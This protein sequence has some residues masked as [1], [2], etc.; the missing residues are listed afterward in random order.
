MTNPAK[1][2]Q[3]IKSQITRFSGKVSQE[4]DKPKR[5]FINEMIYGIQASKD[6][7]L[8]NIARAL[9]EDIS[10]VKTV[11]RLSRQIG[12]KDLT[13]RIGNRLIEEGKPFIGKDTVL[14]LDLSDISKEYSEKQEGFARLRDGSTGKIKD[15]WPILAVVGADVR[16]DK[17]IP[18]Y[19]KLYT[20]R[21]FGFKSENLEILML[22]TNLKVETAE[23]ALKIMEIYLTR[24]KCEES[25]RFIKE[26]Y[27]L[28]DVRVLKYEGLR[29][30]V[31]LIMAVFAVKLR[32]LL[33][34][35]YE[36]S[37][38]LFEIP[39]FKQYAICDGIYNLLFGRKF[40]RQDK[41]ST[42][43]TPQLWLPLNIS[44]F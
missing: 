41:G 12:S 40:S 1:T 32:I 30:I 18:L 15:G 16:G 22:L 29:N 37:K 23:D 28:E 33:K 34:K 35:V 11:G 4:L 13:P 2:A 44:E 17:V 36:K 14:A 7:K 39:P 21:G 19:A 3:Q 38:R 20:K 31:S 43:Q 26:A 27:Q 9:D 25:F 24:W 10:L 5:R 8:A 42:P 6:V